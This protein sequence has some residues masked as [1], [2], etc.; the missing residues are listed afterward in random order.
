[1]SVEQ[2]IEDDHPLSPTAIYER[3]WTALAK[4]L[5]DQDSLWFVA[6]FPSVILVGNWC[7]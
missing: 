3:A 6:S 2:L 5:P 4:H 1:M 7:S